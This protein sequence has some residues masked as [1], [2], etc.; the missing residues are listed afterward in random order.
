MKYK[1]FLSCTC[2]CNSFLIGISVMLQCFVK[3]FGK[4]SLRQPSIWQTYYQISFN[5]GWFNQMEIRVK[6]AQETTYRKRFSDISM[7]WNKNWNKRPSKPVEYEL[8]EQNCM[9]KTFIFIVMDMIRKA[10]EKY[11]NKFIWK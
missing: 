2:F 4:L 11:R 8:V 9:V 6:L 1:S 7:Q 10:D 5:K 3:R